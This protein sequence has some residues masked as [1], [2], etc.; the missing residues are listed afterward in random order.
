[1]GLRNGTPHASGDN[2]VK[3][4]SL[5]AAAVRAGS[6]VETMAGPATATAFAGTFSAGFF[7]HDVTSRKPGRTMLVRNTA[8]RGRRST[9]LM[10]EKESGGCRSHGTRHVLDELGTLMPGIT[11]GRGAP[12]GQGPRRQKAASNRKVLE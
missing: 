1:M 10:G 8:R 7:P 3:S 9:K 5:P 4:L 12:A 2:S 11:R 6:G